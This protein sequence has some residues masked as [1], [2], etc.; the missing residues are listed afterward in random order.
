[1][2]INV[3][4]IVDGDDEVLNIGGVNF[5]LATG[6]NGTSVTAGGV[7]FL[8]DYDVSGTPDAFSI[9]VQGGGTA[10]QA[11]WE[12]LIASITYDNASSTSG[13]REFDIYVN[14]G[15]GNSNVGEAIVHV[16]SPNATI[17]GTDTGSVTEDSAPFSLTTA[18]ALT[19]TDPDNGQAQ[20]ISSTY[21]GVYGDVTINPLGGWTYTASNLNPVIDA[22]DAGETLTDVISVTSVDGTSHDITITI[23]GAMMR[24]SPVRTC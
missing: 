20:F 13:N 8:V 6:V 16:A 15:T 23:N 18:G 10:P 2:T 9:T 12:A 3:S 21:G 14:D 17:G 24:R 1:M 7:N 11:A 19:I 4:G 22:L 5:A